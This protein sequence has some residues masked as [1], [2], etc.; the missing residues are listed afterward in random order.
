[1]K[2]DGIRDLPEGA[3][4]ITFIKD[5]GDTAALM[6]T[7]ACP[8]ASGVE[9]TLRA[10]AIEQAIRSTRQAAGPPPPGRAA[11]TAVYGYPA[12]ID[13][14]LVRRPFALFAGTAVADGLIERGQL[15]D[16]QGFILFDGVT[17]RSDAE[18]RAAGGRAQTWA[19]ERGE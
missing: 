10:R 16:G 8:P 9:M 18:I 3:G 5:F 17:T 15:R 13:P 4:P 12:S 11:V 6:L 2:L 19:A 14:P 7:V 1:M